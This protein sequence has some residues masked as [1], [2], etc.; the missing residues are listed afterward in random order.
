[1]IIK[2][3]HPFNLSFFIIGHKLDND[4]WYKN[5]E[6]GTRVC[7]NICHWIDL[8]LIFFNIQNKVNF[9]FINIY[10]NYSNKNVPDEN[11]VINLNSSRGDIVNIL[12]SVKEEPFEG[13]TEY[14]VYHSE[15]LIVNI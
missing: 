7:G 11:I 4:H 8:S 9:E 12:F 14:L 6:E 5:E 15:N 10:I 3:K 1:M 2:S 13:V